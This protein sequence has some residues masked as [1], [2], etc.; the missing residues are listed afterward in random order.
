MSWD[1]NLTWK[2]EPEFRNLQP[3]IR[4]KA[5]ENLGDEE[6]SNFKIDKF[7]EVIQRSS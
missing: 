1:N 7:D 4:N 6:L 5:K 2:S 3:S